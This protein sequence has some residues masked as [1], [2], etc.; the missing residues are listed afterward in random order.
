MN[1]NVCFPNFK[2][3]RTV[4]MK[5]QAYQ[6]Q[7]IFLMSSKHVLQSKSTLADAPRNQTCNF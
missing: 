6:T 5:C 7:V 4:I 3:K 2:G 1:W